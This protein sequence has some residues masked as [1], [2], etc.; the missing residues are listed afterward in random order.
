MIIFGI[1][2]GLT[3]PGLAVASVT[4][5]TKKVLHAEC[6]IPSDYHTIKR[7][8]EQDFNRVQQIVRH[9][10]S[11]CH[12][13]QPHVVI[14]ELPTG[15][16]K[17][18]GAIRGM[19]YSI[20]M[21]AAIVEGLPNFL[22]KPAIIELI[23]P[24]ENKK[25]GT[26]VTKWKVPIEQGKWEIV[27]AMTNQWPGVNWPRKKRNPVEYDDAKAWAIAD[28]LSCISTFLLKHPAILSDEAPHSTDTSESEA[29][30]NTSD[31]HE[32]HATS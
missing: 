29:R 20:S 4:N 22:Q 2:A 17:S 27:A 11:L 8:S 5:T 12:R 1:D 16:A 6:F 24:L 13:F 14:I 9:T 7:V 10:W 25:G 32:I 15:G 18:A 26:N 28:A 31:R 19:A 3:G 23:T 21:N 30:M